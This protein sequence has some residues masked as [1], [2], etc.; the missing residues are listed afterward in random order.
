MEH[1]DRYSVDADD[2]AGMIAELITCQAN[3]ERSVADL[4]RQMRILRGEWEGLSADAQAIAQE[5]LETGMDTMNAALA[6][7]IRENET[8]RDGYT[9]AW[10]ANLDMWRA[11]Q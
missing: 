5:E 11:V 7:L 1:S 8:A 6:E 10:Q 2:L 4:R 3:L 9:A